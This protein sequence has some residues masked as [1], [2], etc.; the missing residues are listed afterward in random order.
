MGPV[1]ATVRFVCELT[2]LYGIG[3]GVLARTDRLV[4]AVAVPVIAAAVW[5]VFRV[6]DDPGP[7]PVAVPGPVRLLIEAAVFGGGA[8]GL[9]EV[10]GPPAGILFAAI[11]A[12]HYATTTS[13]L[14]HVL[15]E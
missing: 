11:V 12:V 3:A 8:L 2:A 10:G 1:N 15:S 7:A 14:R 13:R 4:A 9:A 6:P 5:G